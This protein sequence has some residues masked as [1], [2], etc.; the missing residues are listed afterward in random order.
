MKKEGWDFPQT[1]QYLAQKAGVVLESQT[2]ERQAEDEEHARLRGLL[3]EAVLFYHHHLQTPAGGEAL[4]YLKQ[5][6]L[7]PDTIDLFG[8]GYAPNAW[9]SA[10]AY[11]TKKGYTPDE[12]L[13]SGIVTERTADHA[14]GRGGVYDRFRNR[15]MFPIR[16]TMGH[17]AG[18]GA[19]ILNPE[20]MPKFLNS[21]QTALF[22]KGRLLYGLDLARKALRAQDQAVIVEGYLDVILLHQ[23]GFSNTVSPMGTALTEDQFRLLK[24]FTRKMVIALDADAA[25]EKATLRGLDV[26]RQ[27]MDHADELVFD[28]RGLLRHEARLQADLRVTTLPPGMDPDEVVLRNPE[29]W[30][31][32]LE[33]A[34]PVVIHVMDTLA[35]A[36]DLNDPK[37]KSTVAA[38]VLPLIEDVPNAVER[39]AYRQRLARLLRVD[40]SALAIAQRRPPRIAR[41]GPIKEGARPAPFI[42]PSINPAR[43][44]LELEAHILR[45]LLRQPEVLNP[46]D[47]SL[48]ENQ[49]SRLGAQDFESTDH[50]LLARRVQDALEQDE[51]EPHQFILRDLPDALADLSQSLLAPMALGEPTSDQLQEDLFKTVLMLRQVRISENIGQLRYLQEELQEQGDLSRGPYHE[52]MLQYAQTLARLNRALAGPVRTE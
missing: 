25:G 19:R 37:A 4:A 28:A 14:E 15:I 20:D 23:A 32:I 40:E 8:L 34:Q 46:L 49:L 10:L 42:S 50:Q 31:H 5:R 2:P 35:K 43:H 48:L 12:L 52:M 7:T 1:L 27:A 33:A 45:L 6:G 41:R 38:D 36:H 21:P 47:R 18:F 26:A 24:R 17:M 13:Q 16:D 29:E 51:L 22:D 3:E 44:G 9:E 30:K 11:F 39:D